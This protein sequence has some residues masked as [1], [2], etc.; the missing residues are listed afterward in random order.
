[1]EEQFHLDH[2][3]PLPGWCCA[4]MGVSLAPLP[5][6]PWPHGFSRGK[7]IPKWTSSDPSTVG[8][9]LGGP[10]SFCLTGISEGICE[11]QALG[12]RYHRDRE[13]GRVHSDQHSYLGE[14]HSTCR[15]AKAELLASGSAQM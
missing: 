13:G 2:I 15:S 5:P 12:T 14:P 9:F 7:E 10:L 6:P 4:V 3:A 1:M 8:C 11:A